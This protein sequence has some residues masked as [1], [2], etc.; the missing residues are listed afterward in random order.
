M[1][2][3]SIPKDFYILDSR[4]ILRTFIEGNN[5]YRNLLS[6]LKEDAE[7]CMCSNTKNE[8]QEFAPSQIAEIKKFGVEV[9]LNEDQ[10]LVVAAAIEKSLSYVRDLSQGDR[11]IKLFILAK[12]KRKKAIILTC[13]DDA[14]PT[15]LMKLAQSLKLPC[16]KIEDLVQ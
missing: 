5:A 3:P 8:V 15:S 2:E 12:A 14:L 7:L 9:V 4:V 13:E 10:D 16:S 11:N 6:E 1:T